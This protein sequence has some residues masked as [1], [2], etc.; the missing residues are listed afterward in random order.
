MP[1]GVEYEVDVASPGVLGGVTHGTQLDISTARGHTYHHA[2]RRGEQAVAAIDHLD[3]SSDHLLAGIEV[4]YD[5]VT[6]RTDG[7][8]VVV[9][10]LIHHLGL[11]TDGYHLIGYAVKGHDRRLIDDNLVI[12]DYDGVGSAKIHRY[13][14]CKRKPAHFVT[15]SYFILSCS[16]L[17]AVSM[18]EMAETCR[19]HGDAVLVAI[20]KRLLVSD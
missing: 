20:V 11:V 2:Q 3:E 12:R 17:M 7:L 16:T 6:Q 19:H 9:H 8:Y 10:L 15:I 4:C 1:W 13:V 18:F 5:S 14:L